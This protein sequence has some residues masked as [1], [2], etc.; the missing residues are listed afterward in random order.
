MRPLFRRL[1]YLF[2]QRKRDADL[3]EELAFH[4]AMKRAELERSGL[5]A[6]DAVFASRRALGNA[7]LSREDARAVWIWRWLDDLWRDLTYGIRSFRRNPVF[8]AV[9][10]LTLALAV[11]ANTAIYTVVDATLLR[12]LPFKDPQRLMRV[13]LTVPSQFGRPPN[14]DLTWSYPKYQTFRQRQKVF[15]DTAIYRLRTQNLTGNEDPERVRVEQV[16]AAY[17]P[18][19]GVTA[20]IGRTFLADEDVTPETHFV[21]LVS[22]GLWQR[23]FGGD[24]SIV[25]T[26][27]HLDLRPHTIVGVLPRDFQALSGPV[28]IWVPAHVVA[29]TDLNQ[30]GAHS[31]EL[32]ARLRSGV[33]EAQAKSEADAI[34]SEL[35]RVYTKSSGWGM[36]A[37]ALREVRTDPAI[38]QS[39][40]MLFGAVSFVLLIACANIMNLLLVRGAGRQREIAVRLAV[41]GGRGRL[42]RQLLTESVLLSA[43][44]A[45]ASLFL[46]WAGVQALTSINPGAANPFGRRLSGL[47]LIG[48]NSIKLDER[49]LLFAFVIAF[50]TGILFGI[51]PALHATRIRVAD[52]LKGIRPQSGTR[53][54]RLI[55]GTNLLVVAE[56]MLALILLVG[57]GLMLKSFERLQANKIGVD[58]QNVLTVRFAP[59]GV[60]SGSVAVFDDL[61]DRVASLPGAIS[62]GI[63]SCHPLAGFCGRTILLF[64]DRLPVE[65]GAEPSVGTNV[66]SANYFKTM[67]IPLIEGRWFTQGDRQGAPRVAVI[68]D[69]AARRFWPGENPVGKPI[70]LGLNGFGKGVEIIGVVGDVRY[71]QIEEPAMPD[72]YISSLQ[73]R[74]P[75]FPGILFVRAAHN[76]LNLVASVREQVR[77]LDKDLTLFDIMTM[78]ARIR[79]AGA[80]ARF[81]SVLMTIFAA[82]ALGLAA[83]GI[84]GVMSSVVTER[85]REIGIRS[86]L[87][88]DPGSVLRLILRRGAVL[89]SAGII[90]G[91][92]GALALTRVLTSSL[93]EVKPDDPATY[94]TV[95][96]LLAGV[97]FVA[98]WIPA[99]RAARIDPI[100][101]LR[102]D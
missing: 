50:A 97:A 95:A 8:S 29:A 40:V 84:Y 87:G 78:E 1:L 63:A 6:A 75:T 30:T 33:T 18:L 91:T 68:N 76:P 34:G 74:S 21:A 102:A 25:G 20:E 45:C 28:D 89:T 66:V 99:R 11:G 81:S 80:R 44:G 72:I 70:G 94:A 69:T 83:V 100:V 60:A 32:I 96:G 57:A 16:S 77:T 51:A 93:Y 88:A 52:A 92:A 31:W 58:P 3:A 38:R 15:E 59:S 67:K 26:T 14:D 22:Q 4:D 101:A 49:A 35:D 53:S 13:A 17:F 36:R 27:L 55:G 19:L 37:V 73:F 98:T 10:V 62:A 79:D 9:V 54:T 24:P 12:P 90:L 48:F 39:V 46:A 56:L 85:T 64:G 5:P 2:R 42:V 43:L 47:T 65:R 61:E 71:G 7:T 86:A 82:M 23:R 41:G